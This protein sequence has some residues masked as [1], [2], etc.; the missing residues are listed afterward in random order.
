MRFLNTSIFR[1]LC[2][3]VIGALLFLYPVEI[4][5]W[6]SIVIGILFIIPGLVSVVAYYTHYNDRVMEN[7]FPMFLLAGWGSILLGAAIL[8]MHSQISNIAFILLGAI[9]IVLAISTFISVLSCRKYYNLGFGNFAVPILVMIV[10]L[11]SI[12]FSNSF[13][14]ET[15]NPNLIFQI[16]GIT[17]AVYGCAEIYYAI[18]LYIG[19]SKYNKRIQAEQ[20]TQEESLKTTE[21]SE[22]SETSEYPENN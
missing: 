13:D 6:V 7:S 12:I 5:Q 14:G 1:A 21:T 10:G 18:R 22:T 3:L 11:V 4:G 16:I 15:L 19:K 9:L 20:A 2:T 17:F 8:L